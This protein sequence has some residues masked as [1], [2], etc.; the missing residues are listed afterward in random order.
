LLSHKKEGVGNWAISC[1]FI[2]RPPFVRM[3]RV[4]IGYMVKGKT[5]VHLKH[6]EM[7]LNH[8]LKVTRRIRWEN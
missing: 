7:C 1:A 4:H 8:Y 5:V 3:M 2:A 6:H